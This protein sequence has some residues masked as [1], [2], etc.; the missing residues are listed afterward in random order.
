M[1]FYHNF[2]LNLMATASSEQQFNKKN[3]RYEAC[4]LQIKLFQWYTGIAEL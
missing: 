4:K 2:C 3:G 1:H